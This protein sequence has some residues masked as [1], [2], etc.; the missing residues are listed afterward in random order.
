MQQENK[1]KQCLQPGPPIKY[2]KYKAQ[3]NLIGKKEKIC[4]KILEVSLDI[5]QR[6]GSSK[7]SPMMAQ[8]YITRATQG[9]IET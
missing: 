5:R 9:T 8:L 1:L 2:Q 4:G 6:V 7:F 3:L